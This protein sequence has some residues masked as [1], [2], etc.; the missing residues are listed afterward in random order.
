LSFRPRGFLALAWESDRTFPFKTLSSSGPSAACHSSQIAFWPVR[1]TG[2]AVRTLAAWADILRSRQRSWDF[3]DPSQ[4]S[5]RPRV[6]ASFNVSRPHADLRSGP[7]NSR[8]WLRDP[9]FGRVKAKGVWASGVYPREQAVLNVVRP[10]L[11]LGTK[12]RSDHTANPAMGFSQRTTLGP[13]G[14]SHRPR[15]LEQQVFVRRVAA[16]LCRVKPPSRLSF[17]A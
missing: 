10:R 3:L 14:V 11:S 15:G 12:G 2:H 17:I 4:C 7:H 9:I 16:I 8:I 13:P 6:S 5:S 1:R